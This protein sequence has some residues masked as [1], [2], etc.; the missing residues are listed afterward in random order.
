MPNF[1]KGD[2][3]KFNQ[4]VGYVVE[5]YLPESGEGE[6]I[7]KIMFAKNILFQ[8]GRLDIVW[9]FTERLEAASVAEY[10]QHLAALKSELDTIYND[11]TKGF[12][13]DWK[14]IA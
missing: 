11:T 14:G 8:M 13:V 4:W 9:Q 1:T 2:Y 7:Y 12:M 10:T 6:P 3:V 5:A